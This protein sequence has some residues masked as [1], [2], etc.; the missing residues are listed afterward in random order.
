[1]SNFWM[2]EASLWFSLVAHHPSLVAHRPFTLP[3]FY[4]KCVLF[5]LKAFLCWYYLVLVVQLSSRLFVEPWSHVFV[6]LAS[7]SK[8]KYWIDLFRATGFTGIKLWRVERVIILFCYFNCN[9]IIYIFVFTS[10]VTFIILILSLSF[11]H[12]NIRLYNKL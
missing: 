6:F 1:M 11:Y 12:S 5:S 3:G 4:V 7:A 2:C 9:L 8:T 10:F